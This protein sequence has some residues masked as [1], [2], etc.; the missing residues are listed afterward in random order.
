MSSDL[1]PRLVKAIHN[2][3]GKNND[4][5][6]F[7]KGDIFTVTQALDGGWWEGTLNGTTG[8]FPSNYV[9]EHRADASKTGRVTSKIA[10]HSP[11]Q[12]HNSMKLYRNMVF[13]DILD[14]EA[15]HIQELQSITST[16]LQALQESDVLSEHDYKILVGNLAL[17]LRVHVDLLAALDRIK[18]L[19]AAEQRVGGAFLQAAAELKTVHKE[20]CSNHPKAVKVLEKFSEPLSQFLEKHGA[21]SPGL[22]TLTTGLS[23]PFR[24]LEK[25]PALLTELQRHTEES[26]VDRGDTQRSV[27][28]YKDIVATCSSLRR[29]KELELEVMTGTINGWEGEEI[30]TLGEITHLGP[31]V[32]VSGDERRDRYLVLFPSTLVILSLASSASNFVYE[33]KVP[34]A[35]LQ[36]T[37]VQD[38][39]ENGQ[40]SFELQGPSMS[41]RLQVVCHSHEDLELWRSFLGGSTPPVS[42]QLKRGSGG[43]P[44]NNVPAPVPPQ[45]AP[46]P[47]PVHRAVSPVPLHPF[48]NEWSPAPDVCVPQPV[49][50]PAQRALPWSLQPHAPLRP[51]PKAQPRIRKHIRR[52]GL[53]VESPSYAD[54]MEILQVIVAYC[55]SAKTRYTV[56]SAMLDSPQVI[57]VEDEKMIVEETKGNVSVLQE[58]SLVDTVYALKDQVKELQ[59]ETMQLMRTVEEERKARRRLEVL[60]RQHVVCTDEPLIITESACR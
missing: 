54:D 42:A 47:V 26:H 10:D 56:N 8:W 41:Q 37:V 14:T 36:L 5:L 4:E 57:V 16:Y 55:S 32:L 18:E 21:N 40:C 39:G 27:F 46:T 11:V 22:L 6:C 43:S 50:A 48:V 13:K 49:V 60:L 1:G 45:R 59:N 12:R 44:R 17:V 51:S 30:H 53:E 34:T 58:K 20:Y 35:G 19:P 25:Y 24:R 2:F 3:K 9:K 23:C 31:V 52:R 33:G 28:V 38:G 29:Q 15:T 7:K